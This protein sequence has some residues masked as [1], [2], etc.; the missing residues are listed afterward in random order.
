MPAMSLNNC[1]ML[2]ADRG[3]HFETSLYDAALRL[4]KHVSSLLNYLIPENIFN[5][6]VPLQNAPWLKGTLPNLEI[7]SQMERP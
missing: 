6:D 5:L 1:A 3:A 4:F 7:T 2:K